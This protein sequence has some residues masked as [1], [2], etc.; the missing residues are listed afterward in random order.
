MEVSIFPLN[1]LYVNVL[2]EGREKILESK[3]EIKALER[4]IKEIELED[5]LNAKAN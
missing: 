3:A 4:K 5:E 1:E 2:S